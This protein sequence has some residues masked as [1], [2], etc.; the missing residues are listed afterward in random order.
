LH[1][2]GFFRGE[3]GPRGKRSVQHLER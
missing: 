1:R 2:V 3:T